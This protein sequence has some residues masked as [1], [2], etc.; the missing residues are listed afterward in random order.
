MLDKNPDMILENNLVEIQ[1][2]FEQNIPNIIFCSEQFHKMEFLNRL[3]EDIHEQII[4]LDMD[5]LYSGYI[6]SKM[7]QKKDN[8]RVI[9]ANKENWNH[10][11]TDIIDK[12][13]KRK[14]FIIVDSL[15]VIYS[16]FNDLDSTIFINSCIML[17]ASV[18]RQTNSSII[19]TAIARKKENNEWVLSP[20]GKQVVKS[21]KTRFYSL[22]K[23]Q[24]DL[25]VASITDTGKTRK[26][27]H[28]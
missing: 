27:D 25:V 18:G 5:L 4:F 6:Q 13:S 24:K 14:I 19:I 7:I 12:V 26:V 20:G 22:R 17:L 10:R 21:D 2:K 16:M 8:V 9:Q 23:K 3:I 1:N 11:L 15:N 28:I